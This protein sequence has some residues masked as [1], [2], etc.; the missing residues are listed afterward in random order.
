MAFATGWRTHTHGS[1]S[2]TSLITYALGQG[3]FITSVDFTW[4]ENIPDTNNTTY[5]RAREIEIQSWAANVVRYGRQCLGFIF[6]IYIHSIYIWS[7]ITMFWMIDSDV[8]FHTQQQLFETPLRSWRSPGHHHHLLQLDACHKGHGEPKVPRC[9]M[10]GG[11]APPNEM[12]VDVCW[13][14]NLQT[15]LTTEYSIYHEPNR[16]PRHKMF[17]SQPRIRELSACSMPLASWTS[18]QMCCEWQACCATYCTTTRVQ[19]SCMQEKPL[20]RSCCSCLFLRTL[21]CFEWFLMFYYVLL[22]IPCSL[23]LDV[24]SRPV[25]HL[26]RMLKLLRPDSILINCARGV[27]V[28]DHGP[29]CSMLLPHASIQ[30]GSIRW[31]VVYI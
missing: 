7:W 25:R 10:T 12:F 24:D 1:R 13:F 23:S 14:I 21:S 17:V 9:F 4:L 20:L 22:G 8:F 29:L 26:D 5:K 27:L 18:P 16:W 31:V 6:D 19:W 30:L 3:I 15:H 28:A 11:R 2:V